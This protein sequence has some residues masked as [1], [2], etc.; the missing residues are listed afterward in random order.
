[1][2]RAGRLDPRED[3]HP[4]DCPWTGGLPPGHI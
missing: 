3:A 2:L 4:G 1:V